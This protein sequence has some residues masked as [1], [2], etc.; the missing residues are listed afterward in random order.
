MTTITYFDD[1]SAVGELLSFWL[2][3]VNIVRDGVVDLSWDPDLGP[4]NE[5]NFNELAGSAVAS[6]VRL[7]A[8]NL[9]IEE[10]DRQAFDDNNLT[11]V[12]GTVTELRFFDVDNDLILRVDDIEASAA[13]LVNFIDAELDNKIFG[14]LFGS[15]GA[16]I[17]GADDSDAD[18][19]VARDGDDSAGAGADWDGDDI[20][21]TYNDDLVRA[22]DGDDLIRDLGGEDDYRGQGGQDTVTYEEWFFLDAV[23]TN[24]IEARFDRGYILGPDGNEDR[25]ASVE[26]ARGTYLD[27]RFI[28]DGNDNLFSGTGGTDFYNGRGG[29]DIVSFE[30]DELFS[31][32]D[33][34]RVDLDD[35]QARDGFRNFETLRNIEGAI[36]TRFGDIF[37]DDDG[38]NWFRGNG[39]DD[40]FIVGQGDDTLIGGSGDDEFV[41]RGRSIGDNVIKDYDE[42]DDSIRFTTATRGEVDV[43]QVGDDVL[44]TYRA[45][46]IRL[47]DTDA[48]DI[49]FNE[50]GL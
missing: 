40:R 7:F 18:W 38:D 17:Q 32:F 24:G 3:D 34:I 31:G 26:G 39:G 23:I 44:I 43:E 47:L 13:L 14:L 11:F 1:N 16:T 27:D 15:D 8:E 21:S 28:G 30:V 42:D 41:F 46:E 19:I 29:L 49:T 50:L 36:G 22:G 45:G 9:V 2:Y 4:I 5:D 20:F 33:R 25:I 48:S 12:S 6:R 35:G 37:R 10:Y